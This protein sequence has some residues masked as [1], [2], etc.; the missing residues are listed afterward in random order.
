VQRRLAGRSGHGV[1]TSGAGHRVPAAAGDECVAIGGGV[2][3]AGK[4]LAQLI[5]GG[6]GLLTTAAD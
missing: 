6:R 2:E 4:Q 1:H 5:G 3:T